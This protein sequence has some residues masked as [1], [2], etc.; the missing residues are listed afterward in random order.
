ME[1]LKTRI[2]TGIVGAAGFLLLLY[3]GSV[4]YTALVFFLATLAY[5]ELM[6][7]KQ[8][9]ITDVHGIMGLFFTWLIVLPGWMWNGDLL[10][11]DYL[12]LFVLLL[13]FLTVASK[14][15]IE[16]PDVA[17]V[18]LGCL[19]VGFGFHYI[20]V[21]RIE[22][23]LAVTLAVLFSIWATDSG[24]YFVGKAVGKTKLWPAISPNKTVEG[25]MG[26]IV[27]AMLVMVLFAVGGVVTLMQALLMGGVIAISGQIGDLIESAVKRTFN[28]K[29]SGTFLP[30]HGGVLDRCDS[31]IIVFPVLHVLHLL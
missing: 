6:R 4:W 24:A 17:Y 1:C 13:L 22:N 12:F 31:W 11:T 7:M 3:L 23:G 16:Y 14:N 28:V 20:N 8:I 19:Y 5:F 30:G 26:G 10:R 29:D 2:I 21:T 25:S 27:L 9:A 15:R 18:L